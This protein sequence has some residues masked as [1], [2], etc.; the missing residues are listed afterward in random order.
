MIFRVPLITPN[1]PAP[2]LLIADYAAI[3]KQGWF[4][5]YGPKEQAFSAGIST[6]LSLPGV[7]TFSSA[8]AGL[9]AAILALVGRGDGTQRILM[10]AFTFAAAAHAVESTGYQIEFVDIESSGLGVDTRTIPLSSEDDSIAALLFCNPFGVGSHLVG[11]WEDAAETLGVP[12]IIDSAAGFGSTYEDGQPVGTRGT[13][14]VFSFHATKPLA[15]GEGGAVVTRD[16]DLAERL[17]S[18]G[19]FGFDDVRQ[20]VRA[21][22]NGKLAELPAAIGLRQLD[23]IDDIVEGRQRTFRLYARLLPQTFFQRNVENSSLCFLTLVLPTG[24]DRAAIGTELAGIGIETRTYYSP[25]LHLHPHF[26]R[27]RASR[28]H[29]TDQ[30]ESRV[31]S[32]PCHANVTEQDVVAIAGIIGAATKETEDRS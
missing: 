1:F 22:F 28:L 23:R 24:V 5:N 20:V 29:G 7:V 16:A 31:L 2:D 11:T 4:S 18:V 27:H 14:E 13:C 21:G 25:S 15:I 6:R 3:T 17:A 26:S 30:V 8:T 10:P 32:L 19:N 9:M 12:L